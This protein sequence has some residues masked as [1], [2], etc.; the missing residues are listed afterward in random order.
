MKQLLVLFCFSGS[1]LFS[2]PQV[3]K[4]PFAHT[5]SIVAYDS[6]SGEIGVAVQ[7]HWFSVGSVVCWGEGGI[8]VVATQSFVNPSF[9]P[10]GIALLKQGLSPEEALQ[11]LLR[12]DEGR[13]YRQVALLDARGNVAAHTGS[14]CIQ[15]AGHIVGKGYSVQANLMANERVWSAMAQAFEQSRGQLAERL[16]AALK[17]A[18]QAGGDIRG[19]QSAAMLVFRGKA[20]GNIWEDK[21]VDIRVD[22]HP[23]PL[24]ELT[25]LL[26]LH[27]AYEHM[28]NG[29]LA[30]EHNEMEKAMAEYSAAMLLCPDN[31]EMKFWT[32]V[33]LVNNNRI[34]EA[35]PLFKKVFSKNSNWK[36]LTPRLLPNGLLKATDKQL[37]LILKEE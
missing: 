21:I 32:A 11:V 13:E 20:T 31:E 1:L 9:G 17:A 23:E 27:R 4:T 19:K 10:R 29:D 36:L 8:G 7:S 15:A 3:W 16:L 24:D 5:Y 34:E 6:V 37:Q 30:V 33:T 2:Q 18:E 26:T 22:D 14:Q 28:N 35:L 12:E 25:R